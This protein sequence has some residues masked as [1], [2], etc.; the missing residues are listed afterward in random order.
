MTEDYEKTAVSGGD[1]ADLAEEELIVADNTYQQGQDTGAAQGQAEAPQST[2]DGTSR[3]PAGAGEGA[4]DIPDDLV[5]IILRQTAESLP[6]HASGGGIVA[7][8]AYKPRTVEE[9][10][11]VFRKM[12]KNK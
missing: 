11:E 10:G 9:A 6:A 5:Q 1:V 12:L 3:M 2:A 8:P 4:A 7:T